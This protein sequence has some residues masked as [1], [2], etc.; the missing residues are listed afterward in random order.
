MLLQIFAAWPE[1]S[2]PAWMT[3]FAIGSRNG[4]ARS[5]CSLVPPTIRARVPAAAAAIP[6]ETGA[7]TKSKPLAFI[8]SPTS[9]ALATS[10]VEQSIRSAPALALGETSFSNTARTCLAAG[11]MVMTTSASFTASAAD[12][13]ARQPPATAFSTASGTRSNARTSW[14]ALARF[15]AIPPPIWPRPMNA[16]RAISSVPSNCPAAS[17]RRRPCLPSGPRFRTGRGTGGA[18]SEC[19]G[20]GESRTRH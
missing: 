20:R 2:C 3:A 6:P 16:M 14:P 4:F 11:S 5:N 8:A 7:S 15:G 19:P 17:R 12:P 18:R 1:P 10:I 9:R 13:A